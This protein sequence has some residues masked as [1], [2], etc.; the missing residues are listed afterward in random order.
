MGW[1]ND[2]MYEY[3]PRTQADWHRENAIERGE[4]NRE[5][6]REAQKEEKKQHEEYVRKHGNGIP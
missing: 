5:N 6:V 3:G 1:L 4:T 2:M